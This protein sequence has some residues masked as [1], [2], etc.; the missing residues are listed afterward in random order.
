MGTP[1]NQSAR[2]ITI[3]DPIVAVLVESGRNLWILGDARGG[4][5][6]TIRGLALAREIGHPDSLSFA[7]VFRAWMHGYREEWEASLGSSSEGLA[8]SA[9]HGLAQTGPW[10]KCVHGW[11]LAHTGRAADGLV[12]LQAGIEESRRIMGQVAMSQFHAML[13]QVLITRGEHAHALDELQRELTAT[14]TS[15]DRYLNA[16]LNRLAAVCHLTLGEPER[17][18]AA[19]NQAIEVA[20]AQGARTFELRAATALGRLWFDRG[21][22]Q[23]AGALVQ[24][25]LDVLGDAEETVDV[26]RARACLIEWTRT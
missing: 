20:R 23:K 1:E 4:L 7:L 15:R 12:E 24:R 19:L 2:L 25:V 6:R 11:A 14:E 21:E 3:Y 5:E 10:N 9:E 26:Q 16:E 18:E 17:A 22:K 8:F 13:A